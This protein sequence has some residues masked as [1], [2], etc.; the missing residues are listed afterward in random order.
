QRVPRVC[1][2]FVFST[3][4]GGHCSGLSKSKARLDDLSGVAGWRIHDLRRTVRTGLAGLRVDP[5]VAERVVGHV[6][7]GGRGVSC[8]HAYLDE[9]RGAAERWAAGLARG[10][11]RWAG[12]GVRR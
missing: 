9:K 7:G 5:D 11:G 10:G 4:A 12:G 6:I 1:D 3:S 2:R 8:R